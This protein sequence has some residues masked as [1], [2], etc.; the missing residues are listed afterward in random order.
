MRE[1]SENKEIL[2]SIMMNKGRIRQLQTENVARKKIIKRRYW[3]TWVNVPSFLNEPFKNTI[4][5][6]AI[7]TH[8]KSTGLNKKEMN[9]S[10]C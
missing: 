3:L 9:K 8:R 5:R 7:L 4:Q 6:V 10:L 2:F 1:H